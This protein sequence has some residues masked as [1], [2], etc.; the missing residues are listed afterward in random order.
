MF[1]R[2]GKKAFGLAVGAGFVGGAV[3]GIYGMQMYHRYKMYQSM[4]YYHGHGGYYGG[5]GYGFR[6]TQCFGGCPIGSFC[7]YGMCR[8]RPDYEDLYGRCWRNQDDFTRR[9]TFNHTKVAVLTITNA[10]I[11]CFVDYLICRQSDWDKRLSPDFD[12]FISCTGHSD[13]LDLDMNMYCSETTNKCQ[14]RESTKWNKES[15]ECQLFMV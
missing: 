15:L 14:C 2:G 8:C 5:S 10:K 9:Y 3:A 1:C 13:C 6:N 4:M 11:D 7:D 12:P